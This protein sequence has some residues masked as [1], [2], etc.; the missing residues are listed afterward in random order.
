ME[1]LFHFIFATLCELVQV[2]CGNETFWRLGR[3]MYDQAGGCILVPMETVKQHNQL[4]SQN[5]V[6]INLV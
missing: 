2:L 3:W 4:P 1:I 5:S 6:D